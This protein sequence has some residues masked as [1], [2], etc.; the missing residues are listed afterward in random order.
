MDRPALCAEAI[1]GYRKEGV[2]ARPTLKRCFCFRGAH[3]NSDIMCSLKLYG[4]RA[5][6]DKRLFVAVK[7]KHRARDGSRICM[8][9]PRRTP[10]KS[11]RLTRVEQVCCYRTLTASLKPRGNSLLACGKFPVLGVGNFADYP[12][13]YQ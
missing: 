6:Y 12:P 10:T 9:T 5:A 8:T 11:T 7:Q 3:Q 13:K 4:M 1:A 2:G